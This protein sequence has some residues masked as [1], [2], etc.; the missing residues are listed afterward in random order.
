MTIKIITDGCADL[1]LEM[2][3]EHD[4]TLVPLY[5]HFGH[6]QFTSNNLDS[7]YFYKRMKTEKEL[8]KTSSPSPYEFYQRYKEAGEDADTLVFC[9]SSK[10]SSTYC[11]A[12][13][14]KDML[15]E[16]GF[17][18]N[19]EI[20]DTKTASVG[21]ARLIIRAAEMAKEGFS[22]QEIISE[23]NKLIAE[24]K[25]FFCL[26]T[27]ENVIKG[28]RLDRVRGTIASVLHIRLVMRADEEG[29][30]DVYEKVRG[31]KNAMKRLIE[32]MGEKKHDLEKNILGVAHGNC[33]E[34]ARAFAEQVLQLYPF[35]KV[36]FA[37]MGPVIGTY[38]GEGAIVVSY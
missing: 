1:P 37:N 23:I 6:E 19:I 30:V 29:K 27:L 16:E 34:R 3:Q 26:E 2:L 10:L 11:H 17:K 12:V 28:G 33:E 36:I 13:M 4:I 25:I 38:G 8:P 7:S 31:T 5:V 24:S 32:I 21:Q 20:F 18:G 22:Y 15:L 9:T 35:K 14:G